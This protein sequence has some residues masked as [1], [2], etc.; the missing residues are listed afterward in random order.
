MVRELAKAGSVAAVGEAGVTISRAGIERVPELE[1]LFHALNDHQTR[2]APTLAN[3]PPRASHEAWLRRRTKYEQWLE[4]PGAFLLVAEHPEPIGFALVSLGEGYDG[5]Q[6]PER[7]ADLHDFTVLP[8]KRRR[9]VGTMLMDAV[10]AELLAAGISYCRLRVIG[11]NLDAL[12]FYEARG[13]TVVS[14]I[15]LGNIAAR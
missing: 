4:K 9:G 15:M 2:V 1:P 7:I 5:W 8:E 10:E 6:S 3:L 14:H 12:R 11:K 13:L